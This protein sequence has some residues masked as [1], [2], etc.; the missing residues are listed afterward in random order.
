VVSDAG[1]P[2]GNGSAAY[3]YTQATANIRITAAGSGVQVQVF[4][5]QLWLGRF[6]PPS[7]AAR[8]SI[9]E[10]A[11]VG[12]SLS[13]VVDPN[14]AQIWGPEQLLRNCEQP[15]GT[16][17]ITDV[18]YSDDQLTRL[19]LEFDQRCSGAKGS[20]RGLVRWDAA[21]TTQPPGP[22]VTPTDAW[23][24]PSSASLPTTGNF[25]YLDGGTGDDLGPGPALLYT[26]DNALIGLSAAGRQLKFVIRG[27]QSW[28][29]NVY[30]MS[31]RQRIE[32][33][34]YP[35]LLDQA[36][37]NPA[38]GALGWSQPTESC[39]GSS[40]GWVAV[41]TANYAGDRLDLLE[42]RFEQRCDT[43]NA[44]PPLRGQIRWS[45]GDRR[46]PP[47][48]QPMPSGLWQPNPL[49]LPGSGSYIYLDSQPGD[50]IGAGVPL[51]LTPAGQDFV[52]YESDGKIEVR[53]GGLGG[54]SGTFKGP[55]GWGRPQAGY[56][57]PLLSAAFGNPARGGLTWTSPGRGCD[58]QG[59]FAV[60]SVTYSHRVLRSLDLRFQQG[61][62]ASGPVQW[63]K[64]HWISPDPVVAAG[65]VDAVTQP[66]ASAPLQVPSSG[67]YVLLD[68]GDDDYIGL[69]GAYLYT[70]ADSG[71]SMV[72]R[73]GQLQVS[74]QGEQR[75][76]SAF[77]P[78]LGQTLGSSASFRLAARTPTAPN[79]AGLNWG[80]EG[81]GCNET[82]GSWSVEGLQTAAEQV[83]SAD[84]IFE[85][86]CDG[87]L[88]PLRGRVHWVGSDTT[89]PPGPVSPPP[90][91]LWQL[92]ASL[93]PTSGN[94]MYLHSPA[95]AFVG[96]G[97]SRLDT[98]AD[99]VIAINT[100]SDEA[101]LVVS[102]PAADGWR[103][104]LAPMTGMSRFA[105]GYYG[106]LKRLI[107]QNPARGG[108]DFGWQSRGCNEL[109][110]WYVI[111]S[112]A[113]DGASIAAIALRFELLCEGVS[114]PVHGQ[115][116]WSR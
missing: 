88:A 29:G 49:V 13:G 26:P 82:H 46:R 94:F 38:K 110:G 111:D 43:G 56:Y 106:D 15:R 63:G 57:G 109:S 67:S 32:V 66:A 107:A 60:D 116:R 79:I 34:Y 114:P 52:L 97:H 23:R 41:D 91:D 54:W 33:G 64:I 100:V 69:G 73:Q 70:K 104:L 112:I 27:D 30:A 85:Q 37:Y 89:V 71:L 17:K 99:A 9:G 87:S 72:Y 40:R 98:S 44:K 22:T 35:L 95:G 6:T 102:N 3:A 8:L 39:Q 113:Y 81:R 84:L 14:G 92:P 2:I 115:L 78:P 51:T 4:G 75:W 21:D 61:C 76:D 12:Y 53:V 86:F 59:W 108:M 24:A 103:L 77:T 19:T 31:S 45:A 36:R 58:T 83:L 101:P 7:G 20:L 93:V 28:I 48:P 80:G 68:S 65:A 105:P 62:A 47:G 50:W 1:D 55:S 90:P 25:V 5:D 42:M 74:V 18:V 16:V 96:D 10:Y 11:N